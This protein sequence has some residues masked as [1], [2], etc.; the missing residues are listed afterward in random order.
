VADPCWG[1][2]RDF[3]IILPAAPEFA[4]ISYVPASD[5]PA[6]TDGNVSMLQMP[7][8]T[9]ITVPNHSSLNP[10]E[11]TLEWRGVID[12]NASGAQVVI[13]KPYSSHDAPYYQYLL[14]YRTD[15]KVIRMDL[16]IGGTRYTALS[17]IGGEMEVIAGQRLHICGTYDGSDMKLY[18][19]GRLVGEEP[20]SGSIN[21]YGE[22]LW[23]GRHGNVT[24]ELADAT[25]DEVRIWSVA[26]TQAEI[27]LNMDRQLAGDES[28]LEGLW[29]FNEDGG[30]TINDS[31]SNANNGTLTGSLH[32]W[33]S[34]TFTWDGVNNEKWHIPCR[35]NI[36]TYDGSGNSVHPSVVYIPD[37]LSGY[38]WWMG[39]TPYPGT[40]NNEY[41]NPSILAS[42]DGVEWEVPGGAS[43][44]LIPGDAGVI[45]NSDSNLLA[46]NDNG[47]TKLFYYYRETIISGTIV[48]I[49]LIKSTDGI[50]WDAPVTVIAH[51]GPLN[52]SPTVF[53]NGD[54][55]IMTAIDYDVEVRRWTSSN[56]INWTETTASTIS[57]MPGGRYLWHLDVLYDAEI[58]RMHIFMTLSTGA[59]GAESRAAYAYSDDDGLNI[60]VVDYLTADLTEIEELQ[61]QG[62]FVLDPDF[63]N[64]Y[65]IFGSS[66][67]GGGGEWYTTLIT[68]RLS[69]GDLYQEN[70]DGKSGTYLSR[71]D[72]KVQI[73]I[74]ASEIDEDLT[75]F[76]IRINIDQSVG[77]N[78][79]DASQIITDLGMSYDARMAALSGEVFDGTNGDALNPLLWQDWTGGFDGWLIQNNQ[80]NAIGMQSGD[81][82]R[83][84]ISKYNL[85][86]L[87]FDIQ[88][89]YNLYNGPATNRWSINLKFTQWDNVNHFRIKR[90]YENDAHEYTVRPRVN[91][92]NGTEQRIA[93]SD[94]DGK[95]R[96]TR[97]GNNFA[98]YFWNGSGWTQ[99][100]TDD[101]IDCDDLYLLMEAEVSGG[102]P[103]VD[104]SF[105]NLI[106]NS[107]T[108]EWPFDIYGEN[109]YKIAITK[110]DEE[111]QQFVEIENVGSLVLNTMVPL[112]S[113]TID[114]V[115]WLHWDST[116]T[117]TDNTNYVGVPRESAAQ[118]VWNSDFV[119]V[120]HLNNFVD[121]STSYDIQG[122][123]VHLEDNDIVGGLKN[124]KAI[125]F[126][127]TEERINWGS[128]AHI[129]DIPLMT[130][131]ALFKARS[132]GGGN[133]GRLLD[134]VGW[135]FTLDEITNSLFF[136]RGSSSGLVEW[137]NT[138][139]L[140]TW[141]YRI[142][143]VM[144]NSKIDEN[145]SNFPVAVQLS[146]ANGNAHFFDEMDDNGRKVTFTDSDGVTQLF[147][148]LEYIGNRKAVYHIKVPIVSSVLNTTI[149]I[150]YD[151]GM[152]DETTYL[153]DAVSGNSVWDDNFKLI[154]HLSQ[155]PSG[156][157]SILDS[158][159]N[160]NDGSPVGSMDGSDLVDA[161]PGLGLQFNGTNQAVSFPYNILIAETEVTFECIW[162]ADAEKS[163]EER[164]Y[165]YCDTNELYHVIK[166]N[167]GGAAGTVGIDFQTSF[168]T[169]TISTSAYDLAESHHYVTRAIES[170]LVDFWIDGTEIG[171][172]TQ[173]MNFIGVVTEGNN[174]GAS[175][176]LNNE[177][178]GNMSEYR[179]SNI[180]RSDAWVKATNETLMNTL[181]D[182]GDV[183]EE[184]A[185]LLP[186][187]PW[188]NWHYGAVTHDNTSID[189]D[190]EFHLDDAAGTPIGLWE[191][192]NL[193]T[194]TEVDPNSDITLTADKAEFDTMQQVAN[195]Y[196]YKDFG[197]DYFGDFEVDFEAE[198]TYSDASV[199]QVVLC[200]FSNTIGSKQTMV[201]A[202]DGL[203]MSINYV[204]NGSTITTAIKCLD[205][206]DWDI[207]VEGGSTVPL[208]YYTFK[209]SG[210]VLTLDIYSD[211]ARLILVDALS[212]DCEI[213][214]K[215]YFYA[216]A[217]QGVGT[218][219]PMSGYTQNFKIPHGTWESDAP[220][221][222]NIGNTGDE[223]RGFDG[224]LG[225]LRI[226]K[227][228][229]SEAWRTATYK[230][231]NDQLTLYDTGFFALF[232]VIDEELDYT[233]LNEKMS[234]DTMH[235]YV[236]SYAYKD[237]GA[238]YF[239]NFEVNFEVKIDDIMSNAGGDII[240]I[241][242]T[243]GTQ[244]DQM[245]GGNGIGMWAY[246]SGGAP[247]LRFAIKDWT[248][249]D[250][251]S[252]YT[253][254]GSSSDLLYC[255]V[256]KTGNIA[257]CKFFSDAARTNRLA[258]IVYGDA[259]PTGASRY[260]SIT[261]RDSLTAGSDTWTGYTQ[262]WEII[263]TDY[264]GGAP[265]EDL[266]TYT[267]VNSENKLA[268][269]NTTVAWSDLDQNDAFYCYKDFGVDYFGDY[270]IE[271]ESEMFDS[272]QSTCQVT[273]IAL[274]ND[275][276]TWETFNSQDAGILFD[277]WYVSNIWNFR[278][279]DFNGD[280][281]DIDSTTIGNVKNWGPFYFK[282]ERSGTTCT[283]KVYDDSNRTNLII[284]LSI[285]GQSTRYR[286]MYVV[287]CRDA[288]GAT[289]C[290]GHSRNF[291]S[292]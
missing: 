102:Y 35:L 92:S 69:S 181:S 149:Y 156:A 20:V 160:G 184:G 112:I 249:S 186:A 86:D 207:F 210:T 84:T 22:S 240:V 289:P 120:T 53:H 9:Y 180:Y 218:T 236:V 15:Q 216:L 75:D 152:P 105:D 221:T 259:D 165:A 239:K 166:I 215:R 134:K 196:V 203:V 280:A 201:N 257:V 90:T 76:P 268:A 1:H 232:T 116:L 195:S 52:I 10:T 80:A 277:A 7:F 283:C 217:G 183:E 98:G 47:T 142:P 115:M 150:Y 147:A 237:F 260:M 161:I 235:R 174:I 12:G 32:S 171:E 94:T 241:S 23:F 188:D 157:D 278:L 78:T 204:S 285:T 43:N 44:P 17:D 273:F 292:A 71:F 290:W 103:A 74:P 16:T 131:E 190:P 151:A 99:I 73:I 250:A 109:Q 286:Y 63:K 255:T 30:T 81:V 209:R 5:Y 205:E 118:A 193:L 264:D 182:F 252:T 39:V 65:W 177:A 67:G 200:A 27:A 230:T 124:G 212:C 253:H 220:N 85:G 100:G 251:A 123:P 82:A 199:P 140:G 189:N 137:T 287:N 146:D 42:N 291:I 26:R 256:M 247:N 66:Y 130:V 141:A 57:G 91:S 24:T 248:G 8:D 222:L 79:V 265:Y 226:S 229:R 206:N 36:P 125:E 37:G 238:D 144:D 139:W 28:G 223:D 45:F 185:M 136:E 97:I 143:I 263:E 245:D 111:T 158:T 282:F 126:D 19:N 18:L 38:N 258:M 114:T 3:D 225:E 284:S 88:I 170:S 96:V 117:V 70:G 72:S 279:R 25:F 68:R 231:L 178:A 49:K 187:V 121:E 172:N 101:V 162:K 148:E 224:L 135:S 266:E 214:N 54:E 211:S 29:L 197:V 202:T 21:G 246:G 192:D 276:G 269:Y 270:D 2:S 261:N 169:H 119:F 244:Q 173:A 129:D 267:M 281:Q 133:Y 219:S 228:I 154:A 179:I 274:G 159:G 14:A 93:T 87:D 198:I 40:G 234:W 55:F 138:A 106:I 48:N 275:L 51:D 208:R 242:N 110:E 127:G 176:S 31:T 104:V 11:I 153:G 155:V 107:G 77:L 113:S 194:Y 46:I 50:N 13:E 95:L 89:D 262:N 4:E 243:I 108:V 128:G 233:K 191:S 6:A 227:V 163:S 272:M 288:G 83:H 167:K 145:L 34:T 122:T 213:G 132:W 168:G 60:T 61:Y 254:G 41:E 62:C 59:G 56:G 58:D 64:R 33:N 175:R 271:W 164:A